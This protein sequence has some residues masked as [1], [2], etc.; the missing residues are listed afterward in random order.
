MFAVAPDTPLDAAATLELSL[1]WLARIRELDIPA[2]FAAQDGAQRPGLI[3]WDEF[4]V[5]FLGGSTEWK[6]GPIA[7]Q[8]AAEAKARGKRLHMGRV[9]SR[10][11]LG[12]AAWIGCHSVD[13]TF[14]T[15]APDLNLAR[16]LGWI[17]DLEQT[18]HLESS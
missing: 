7:Q 14:L 8:L 9:N 13:G 12:L 6:T 1:P 17:H 16:L 11:R 5:L 4:D 2:A 10:R 3:P 18:P 15:Y